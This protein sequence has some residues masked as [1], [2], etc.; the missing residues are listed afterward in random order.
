HQIAFQLRQNESRKY[1]QRALDTYVN[2]PFRGIDWFTQGMS[3]E[4]QGR[5][6][7]EDEWRR[8]AAR[9]GAV[10]PYLAR[11]RANLEAGL[12]ARNTPDWRMVERDGLAASEAN[13]VY[14]EKTLPEMA[15]ERIKGQPF[16]ERVLGDLRT[17]GTAA[18]RA[19]R[20]LR[21]F[22]Q[23]GLAARP[24]ADRYASGEAEYDWALQN[25]LNLRGETAA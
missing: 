22:L 8:V 23:A 9:V 25:N 4:G 3:D 13:A 19:F 12:H 2:E 5:Y 1:W 24:H 16:S 20:E 11:A 14:F 15:A 18:A 21:R 17:R 6:G 10:G 7:N